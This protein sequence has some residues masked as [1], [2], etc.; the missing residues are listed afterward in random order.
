[1]ALSEEWKTAYRIRYGHLEYTVMP[2]SLTNTS[3]TFEQL[4]NDCLKE[5]L[6]LFCTAYLND[7]LIYSDT[8]AQHEDHE[9]K[10]LITL[11]A[12]E[13]LLNTEKC[14]F[15]TKTTKYLGLIMSP[16]GISKNLAKV[17]AI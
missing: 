9:R 2:F 14:R 16:E 7:I 6:D 15:H 10:V 13:V 17:S 8:P 11:Q 4:V 3:T 5:S 1:M 12:N